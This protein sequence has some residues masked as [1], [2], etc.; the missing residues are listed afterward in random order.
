M[1]AVRRLASGSGSASWMH[2]EVRESAAVLVLEL[3]ARKD[4]RPGALLVT[5]NGICAPSLS[6]T[7]GPAPA[8]MACV[9]V[10]AGVG[11][12]VWCWCW[13]WCS[14][15]RAEGRTPRRDGAGAGR[16]AVWASL[17]VACGLWYV[18]APTPNISIRVLPS[19]LPFAFFFACFLL[20]HAACRCARHA[21]PRLGT[22]GTALPGP[23]RV[24]RPGR[25]QG[26]NPGEGEARPQTVRRV[27]ELARTCRPVST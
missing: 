3:L 5:G 25:P 14:W 15:L 23:G 24:E 10:L 26:P 19:L 2:F 13:C 21:S 22:G 4:L 1:V 6:R 16:W 20:Q 11:A 12:G 18:V 17:R 9:L 27:L 8:S 7:C